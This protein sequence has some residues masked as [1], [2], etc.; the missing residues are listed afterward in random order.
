MTPPFDESPAR[1]AECL[2]L[3]PPPMAREAARPHPWSRRRLVRARGRP[4]RG[5]ERR[6]RAAAGRRRPAGRA[7]TSTV[8]TRRYVADDRLGVAE[9]VAAGLGGMLQTVGD[10]ARS[11]GTHSARLRLRAR[12]PGGGARR[13]P[14]SA[15]PSSWPR[16]ATAP[17]RCARPPARCRAG[18]TRPMPRWRG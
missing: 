3:A 13:R 10:A 2:R 6:A 4:R 7:P 11:A 16:C 17:A 12:G 5:A 15:R 1:A 9:Q 14:G 8:S 18:W